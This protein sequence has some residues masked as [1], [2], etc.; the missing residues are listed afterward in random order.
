M[1]SG[2]GKGQIYADGLCLTSPLESG[3][4]NELSSAAVSQAFGLCHGWKIFSE[5]DPFSSS[6]CTAVG[7]GGYWFWKPFG[8]AFKGLSTILALEALAV[9]LS[10]HSCGLSSLTF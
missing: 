10:C 4:F 2:A 3:S 7:L 6:S 8:L 5:N 1:L 9:S